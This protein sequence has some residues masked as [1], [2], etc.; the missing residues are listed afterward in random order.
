MVR[1]PIKR[2]LGKRLAGILPGVLV[3]GLAFLIWLLRPL[4]T[5][6]AMPPKTLTYAEA[7]TA[8]EQK[9]AETPSSVR[10]DSRPVV[11][12][13]GAPAERVYVLLHG[14][15]NSPAQFNKLGHILYERGANVVIPRMP[16]HGEKDRLT[17]SWKGI[18]AQEFADSASEAA[19]L[20]RPLGKHLTVVGLSVNG[21]CAAF[22]AQTR[23]DIDQVV[24][25][26]PFLG[27]KGL[28]QWLLTP[29]ARLLVTLPNA[30]LWWNP[31]LKDQAPAPPQTYPRFPTHVI[32]QVIILGQSVMRSA[33][34]EPPKAG[35]IIVVTTNADKAVNNHIN[36]RLIALWQAKRPEAVTTHVFTKE[37][38]V[39]HDF[40]DPA[41][42][43]QKTDFV[44]PILINLM[45][46]R[47]A[48]DL[49]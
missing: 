11:L 37:E 24:V 20:A 18:T 6:G 15:S 48:T 43:Y 12:S 41:Q 27:P 30:F 32:G 49:Q 38:N 22:L 16:H 5:V 19:T 42:T 31:Q 40:I 44:Y 23:S 47:S 34:T 45:E 39:M 21:T 3:L 25:L 13:H 1:N 14:L 33:R 28:P 17:D 35:H 46:G 36:K 10:E 2:S 4:P 9:I 8:L 7:M 26:A 29:T